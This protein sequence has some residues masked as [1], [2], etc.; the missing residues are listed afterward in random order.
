M[1]T[2]VAAK[3]RRL[4]LNVQ[5]GWSGFVFLALALIM[6]TW[7]VA[8]A[9][10]DEGLGILVLVT[11][12]AVV[13]SLF[14]AKSHFPWFITHLFSFV[15]GVAWI[16]LLLSFRLPDT[17]TPR[18]RLLE[19]G[20]RIGSWFQR[21]V[22]GGQ[23]GTDPLMFTVVM[24]ILFW[25]TTYL[26]VWFSFRAHNLW[27]ALLPGGIILL[28]NLYYGPERIAFALVPY[29]L[30]VLLFA[31]R[32]NLYTQEARWRRGRVRYDSDIVFTFLR[33]GA[34][35]AVLAI[36]LAWVVPSAASSQQAE[37]FFSRFNE[38]WERTKEE[39]IRLFST[40]QSERA[41][42]SY[43]SFGGTLEM[44]GA[45]NLGNATLMDVQSPTGQYWRAAVYDVYTGEGWIASNN[46]T[47]F[48]DAGVP[49]GEFVPHEAR[50]VITQTFSLYMP[51]ATQLYAL[52]QPERFSM[53]VK[54]DVVRVESDA[55][56][57]QVATMSMINSR[58]KL[59]SG[60][61]YVAV[62]TIPSADVEAMRQSGDNLPA[63]TERYLQLPGDLPE[64]VRELA[65]EI[66][67][68]EDNIYDKA[69]AIERFLREYTYNEQIERPPLGVDR[70]DY[71]L[72]D[73]QEGYCNYYAS[74]MA[75]MARSVGIPARVA[76]GYTRGDWERDAQ[77]N[78]VREHHSHAWVEVYLPRFGWIEFE[79]TA[80]Q[81]LIVRPRTAGSD[82]QNAGGN[83][84]EEFGPEDYLED[85][86]LG[87]GGPF[88]AEQF[89]R[90]LAE[91]RR[92]E[93]IR[94]WTRVGGVLAAGVA[95]ILIAWWIGRRRMDVE[96]PAGV[97]YESMVRQ[98]GWWGQKWR[99]THT[100]NEFGGQLATSLADE[101]GDRLVH[102]ITN[103]YV[104]ERYGKKNPARYQPDFAW[105]DLRPMLTRWGIKHKLTRSFKRPPPETEE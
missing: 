22:L 91:Q 46:E 13:A 38:P 2:S 99:S 77:V 98:A 45:V 60:D 82:S 18:D 15:F 73:L 50:R 36:T 89:E 30:F 68:D 103:A 97:Y 69:T 56:A 66:T 101:E 11:I 58:H 17:F 40:L 21:S 16:A 52:G 104:G 92:E 83:A 94:T 49:P 47:V 39:W 62:S 76:A 57:G 79:P 4:E 96:R 29:L 27:L 90:M 67:A 54:A 12:G 3:R 14:L 93:M 25:L 19:L 41:D 87:Q 71:F 33:Y 53:P 37:I 42:P 95:L 10:Y 24:A 43:A 88:D 100:P 102:R 26:A 65:Q 6:V 64:R 70:V 105:R 44:G 61:S 35:L 72:F 34:T 86:L 80:S 7:S 23:L 5:E 85:D 32:Y 48:L 63:W 1:M 55:D 8:E 51:G 74:S 9:G 81:A 28:F 20:Y 31:V 59:E 75:V 78:R 84:S